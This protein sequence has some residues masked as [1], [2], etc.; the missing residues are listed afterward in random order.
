MMSLYNT[1]DLNNL[2]K[3]NK[4]K[5]ISDIEYALKN[6]E[7]FTTTVQISLDCGKYWLL[8]EQTNIMP[9]TN[10]ILNYNYVCYYDSDNKLF[11]DCHNKHFY[12]NNNL[13]EIII[14][15]NGQ[16]QIL[17]KGIHINDTNYKNTYE[18]N[19]LKYDEEINK[20][21]NEINME[22]KLIDELSCIIKDCYV[23]EENINTLVTYIKINIKKHRKRH[24]DKLLD[25]YKLLD[26]IS[27]DDIYTGFEKPDVRTLYMEKNIMNIKAM[28]NIGKHHN[29]INVNN[30]T[31]ISSSTVLRKQLKDNIMLRNSFITTIKKNT[32]DKCNNTS[33]NIF[34]HTLNKNPENFS[35]DKNIYNEI[36]CNNYVLLLIKERLD[37]YL[38]F[39]EKVKNNLINNPEYIVDEK[40]SF[41]KILK[42]KNGQKLIYKLSK[43]ELKSKIWNERNDGNIIFD[44]IYL[45]NLYPFLTFVKNKNSEI[46]NGIGFIIAKDKI[47]NKWNIFP[48]DDDEI[49]YNNILKIP[50]NEQIHNYVSVN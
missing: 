16:G 10:I 30:T 38:N 18:N 44:T 49:N 42:N 33:Y 50:Y 25:N 19:K 39:L 2:N 37:L 17:T 7:N 32:Y 24:N 36:I 48:S 22:E 40:N 3:E 15:P 14:S 5:F 6:N 23:D 8:P 11:V 34:R 4:N 46:I 35:N 28:K 47:N 20:R 21:L 29:I 13:K 43:K 1:I 12:K 26:E 27:L 41:T 31:N 9:H 45:V